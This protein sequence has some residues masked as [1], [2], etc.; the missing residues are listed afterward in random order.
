M[1]P[2]Q[3][4]LGLFWGAILEGFGSIWAYFGGYYG[5]FSWLWAHLG[6]FLRVLGPFGPM[7]RRL[8][9]FEDVLWG[10]RGHF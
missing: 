3:S 8:R 10:L 5:R 9:S 1:R 4:V 2:F 7:F 6:L